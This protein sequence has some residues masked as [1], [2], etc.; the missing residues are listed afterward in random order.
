MR[1]LIPLSYM[2]IKYEAMHSSRLAWAEQELL[3]GYI[4]NLQ[5][6]ASCCPLLSVFMLS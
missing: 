5:I 1:I 3:V 6:E 2:S 4:F